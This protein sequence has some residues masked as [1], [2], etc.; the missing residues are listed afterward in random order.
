MK[1][2]V[3]SVEWENSSSFL[4]NHTLTITVQK[5][6]DSSKTGNCKKGPQMYVHGPQ[7]FADALRHAGI[8]V[9]QTSSH[10]EDLISYQLYFPSGCRMVIAVPM[11]IPCEKSKKCNDMNRNK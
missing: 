4:L 1:G 2:T 5:L 7:I 9:R 11:K 3:R 8:E 6:R 10:D